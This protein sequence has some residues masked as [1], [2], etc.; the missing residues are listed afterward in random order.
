VI[1][2][3][4]VPVSG[5]RVYAMVADR[6]PRAR[7]ADVIA[8]TD[9]NGGFF[10][11]C[12]EP[13]RSGVY[14]KEDNYYPDTLRAPFIDPRLIT[15]VNVANQGVTRG[16]EVHLP[17]KGVRVVVQVV[18]AN[19]RRRIDGATLTFCRSN[20]PKDC[21]TVNAN[22]TEMGYSQLLPA[23]SLTIKASAPGHGDWYYG[24]DGSK[25]HASIVRLV[26]ETTRT[27][28]IALR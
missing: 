17:P 13:G 15:K 19:T 11:G 2:Q 18:D 6:P 26:P 12:V 28:L 16:V 24:S 14:T 9:E 5:V 4:G 22:L 10:L 7:S 27:L 23:L 1:A 20:N 21:R 3:N 8:I 25:S